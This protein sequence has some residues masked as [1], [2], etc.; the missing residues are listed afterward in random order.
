MR[1]P[2]TLFRKHEV[3]DAPFASLRLA[4]YNPD[5]LRTASQRR[6]V[7]GWVAPAGIG[8]PAGNDRR[9]RTFG[10]APLRGGVRPFGCSG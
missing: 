4:C 5:G 2:C 3:W 9:T 1:L 8:N 7:P 10:S 6:H